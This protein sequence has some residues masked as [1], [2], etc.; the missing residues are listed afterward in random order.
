MTPSNI[1]AI[2]ILI[3]ALGAL[4][5]VV[6]KM[7]RRPFFESL[8]LATLTI[9]I[10]KQEKEDKT[11]L[12]EEINKSEKLF[13]ALA[14]LKQ[15]FVFELAVHNTGEAINFYLAV[16]RAQVDFATRQVQGLFPEAQVSPSSDYTIFSGDG[17]TAV[18]NLALKAKAV[19][20]IRTYREAEVDTFAPMVSTFSHL[21]DVGE[22]A[23]FQLVVKPAGD[24][25]RKSILES[26]ARLKK[27]E[28]LA[29]IIST[30]FLTA[31]DITDAFSTN[32]KSK[33]D[34]FKNVDEDAVKALS[35]KVA[36]PLFSVNARLVASA[37][38][39]DKAEDIL[40]SVAGA[41]S[42]FTA[43]LRNSF[44][45]I[46]PRQTKK[47]VFSYIF[48][49]YDA[50]AAL[51]LNSEELASVFHL[52]TATTDVPRIAW[53]KFHEAAPPANLPA[54]GA[55]L[56]E[57]IFRGEKRPVRLLDDDRRRHLYTVGQ[58]GTGKSYLMLN[59]AV[60]DMNNGKGLAIIDPHGELIDKV[61]ALVPPHRID[62]VI[63]FNPGDLS[64]PLGLNM[65]DYNQDRPEEK[66]FIVNEIQSIFNRLFDKET[67][68]PMF[69]QYMRNS[70][71]LL[72]EDA[73]YEPATLM[74][75]PRIFTDPEFRK[76]KLA[77]ATNPTVIDF[78]EKE[79]I[80]TS[81]E[82]GLANMTPYIT[83]K[84]G[85]FIANDYMRPIIGQA[86]SAFNFRQVMDE[87]KILLVNLAKGRIGDI[88]AGLL[89]MII[90]GRLLL[91]ALSR[92]DIDEKDRR[93]FYLYVDEFQNFTTDSI[94]VILSEARK[95]H[96]N[97]TLAHQFIAQLTDQIREAVFGNVGSMAAFRV[98]ATDTEHLVKHFGPTFTER[99]LITIENQNAIAKILIKGE[100]STPF[101]FK[102][103]SAPQGSAEV[104][105][106][107]KELSR[108]TYGRD[109]AEV[110]QE[111]LT[112]LRG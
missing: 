78:W 92:T 54:E 86:Q 31:K 100:P 23:A 74:E 45:I 47:L 50:G 68:G 9:T 104:R 32:Q 96:L 35:Q 106:K 10:P 95:Y 8:S 38:T 49:E 77:R 101:N 81:G 4:V 108:L 112:R 62:D 27:G 70:L 99:D 69:E 34:E 11:N 21:N 110:E 19:L 73:K 39:R 84:F 91:A 79:A 83:S 52:P 88:N 64:R 43:P 63:V 51:T 12:I 61:L 72:M 44:Q 102:T 71:L 109:L 37:D 58:T 111:I 30:K 82:Q 65:L 29:D 40:L 93:D 6:I 90:T 60:Q 42:Q 105:D 94:A 97:L 48:R 22:G 16:P 36:K 55:L 53:Q 33:D 3:I 103:V 76:K 75:V 66:T 1:L 14:A 24:G 89:G 59:L 87:G 25:A 20:P 57:S 67:M 18:A 98:G 15:P 80:K 17:A 107:L 56:G 85:N 41:F 13:D 28:K 46:R 2:A 5:W 26:L 7:L